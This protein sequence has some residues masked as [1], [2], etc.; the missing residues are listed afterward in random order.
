LAYHKPLRGADGGRAVGGVAARDLGKGADYRYD[1]D[2]EDRGVSG[3]RLGGAVQ[4]TSFEKGLCRYLI[5]GSTDTS[6]IQGN[7]I[8]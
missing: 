8:I 1:G 2:N 4:W 3:K 5:L 6:A 7:R